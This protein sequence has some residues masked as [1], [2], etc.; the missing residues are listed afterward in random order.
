VIPDA[1]ALAGLEHRVGRLLVV[2]VTLSAAVLAV[3]LTLFLISPDARLGTRV[4]DA[5]LIILMATP[6]LR[7]MISVVEYVR[8]REWFFALITLA[9]LLVLSVT[10][11][12]ALQQ[13]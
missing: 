12:Y 11:F 8:M 6:I 4:I 9:V 5:G 10:V 3:G 7:V 1:D 2:G 13:R